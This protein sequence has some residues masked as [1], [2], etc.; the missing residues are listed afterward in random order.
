MLL[1]GAIVDSSKSRF[2]KR[3]PG[4]GLLVDYQ[5]PL[6]PLWFS[7]QYAFVRDLRSF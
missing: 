3:D 4:T 6:R 2:P 5:D 7:W 1:G